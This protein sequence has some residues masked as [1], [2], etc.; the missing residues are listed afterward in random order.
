MFILKH[1]DADI[2]Y[3]F[4]KGGFAIRDSKLYLSIETT[5]VDNQTFP[6]NFLFALARYPIDGSARS[7][8]IKISN[9]DPNDTLPSAFVYTTFHAAKVDAEIDLNFISDDEM[10]ISISV[11]SEDVNYYDER[12]K[13]NPFIGTAKLTRKDLNNLWIPG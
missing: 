6:E 10:E 4:D 7:L 5:A 1:Q 2:Y 3:E 11:M 12:A 13:L 8:K 9:S